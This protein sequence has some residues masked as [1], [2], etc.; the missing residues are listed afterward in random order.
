MYIPLLYLIGCG[1]TEVEDNTQNSSEKTEVTSTEK[2]EP[3]GE[4][5]QETKTSEKS[6]DE[7]KVD[8]EIN[9]KEETT[10]QESEE[11]KTVST[12]IADLITLERLGNIPALNIPE[13]QPLEGSSCHYSIDM[14]RSKIYSTFRMK[15]WGSALASPLLVTYDGKSLQHVSPKDIQKSQNEKTCDGIYSFPAKEIVISSSEENIDTSKL[16]VGL[17]AEFPFEQFDSEFWWIY[18]KTQLRV[19]L[20]ESKELYEKE[21]EVNV[22]LRKMG[23]AKEIPHLLIN[24]E[25]HEFTFDEES[26]LFSF[27]KP[28]SISS[29]AFVIYTVVPSGCSDMLIEDFSLTIDDQ[30]YSVLEKKS[31][32]ESN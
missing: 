25:K 21:V 14:K 19:I 6:V 30:K 20:A 13:I 3:Q 4:K 24:K 27:S 5:N 26:N 17:R 23:G 29:S 7:E 9:E 2:S 1:Q 32:K 12:S 15:R 28:F 22:Q 11:E 18:T 16:S 8:E 31:V 10:E